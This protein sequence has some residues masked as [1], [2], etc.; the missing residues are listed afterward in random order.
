MNEMRPVLGPNLHPTR[1]TLS[2]RY[3][4]LPHVQNPNTIHNLK[5]RMKLDLHWLLEDWNFLRLTVK[6]QPML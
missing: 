4:N 6:S 2:A 5:V 3:S 1:I